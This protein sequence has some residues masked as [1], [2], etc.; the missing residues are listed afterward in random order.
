MSNEKRFDAEAVARAIEEAA[1][2]PIYK[3][4]WRG[5]LLDQVQR[6][7]DA[8]RRSGVEEAAAFVSRKAGPTRGTLSVVAAGIRALIGGEKR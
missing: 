4:A 8:G 1:E 5:F 3:E 7:F 2:K 6:A